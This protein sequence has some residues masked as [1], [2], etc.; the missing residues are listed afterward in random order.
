MDTFLAGSKAAPPV[1]DSAAGSG[2]SVYEVGKNSAA[3]DATEASSDIASLIY[4]IERFNEWFRAQSPQPNHLIAA[5]LPNYRIATLATQSIRLD[6]VYLGVPHKVIM[7]SDKAFSSESVGPLIDQLYKKYRKRDDFHELLFFLLSEKFRVG[8][9][10]KYWEYL[11]ILPGFQDL[12]HLPLLWTKQQI[13]TDLSS[14]FVSDVILAYQEKTY[15]TYNSIKKN[16]IIQNY[17]G[18]DLLVY[19]NYQW[20]TAILD[21]RSIWWH[22]KRHLV[23]MLDLINCREE[24]HYPS[25]VHSTNFDETKNIAVTKAG[26]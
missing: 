3:I 12:S 11:E 17:L 23:P 8:N 21:S 7:D 9:A 5:Y 18:A 20:A 4:K 14:S 16:E 22:G 19:R 1:L 6:E 25:R 26:E 15:L 2:T 13:K 24:T 10:S